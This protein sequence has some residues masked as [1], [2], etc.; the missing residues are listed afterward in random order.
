MSVVSTYDG[1]ASSSIGEANLSF[2]RKADPRAGTARGVILCHGAS[3]T[4]SR[5]L[6]ATNVPEQNR[7]VRAITDAGYP[8]LAHRQMSDGWASD[9]AIAKVALAKTYLQGTLGAKSG[10]II[11]FGTSMGGALAMAYARAN[12]TLVQALVLFLPVSDVQDIVTNNRGGLASSVNAAYSGGYSD[13]TYGAT[14]NPTLFASSLAGIPV[15]TFYATDDAIVIPS[16]V[17]TV[18]TAIGGVDLHAVT[19]GHAD[20]ALAT[21]PASTVVSFIASVG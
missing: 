19:G 1:S 9:A 8:C 6:D 16:T 21:I 18:M 17:T 15:Q 5:Y 13:G 3:V 20:A 2:L 7:V 12:P 4:E 14:H 10:K 11:L